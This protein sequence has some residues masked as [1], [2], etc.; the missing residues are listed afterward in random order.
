MRELRKVTTALKSYLTAMTL[1][2]C[3]SGA[4]AQDGASNDVHFGF[5][6][7]TRFFGGIPLGV[8]YDHAIDDEFTVGG[9]VGY[10]RYTQR[11]SFLTD[12][13]YR[14]NIINIGPRATYHP[15]LDLDV[16]GLD[17][18]AGAV[19]G[20]SIVTD[21]FDDQFGFSPLR[22]RL[23]YGFL[24]GANYN[25]TERIGVYGEVGYGIA[26]LSA[27]LNVNLN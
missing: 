3:T 21:N 19:L 4:V 25:F 1:V 12:F 5:G 18:Y 14:V 27:G 6:I 26:I 2:L 8:S 17:P 15:D 9:Y 22:S 16:D 24:I 23:L 13:R 20:V 11:F 7:G 10:Q